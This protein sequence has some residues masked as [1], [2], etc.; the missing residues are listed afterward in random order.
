M[1]RDILLQ[2]LRRN[3]L[4]EVLVLPMAQVI[5]ARRMPTLIPVLA[6]TKGT[7]ESAITPKED[8]V[9][10]ERGTMIAMMVLGVAMRQRSA[11]VE[12]KETGEQKEMKSRTSMTSW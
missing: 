4:E 6:A 1:M 12:A 11:M 3:L 10:V 2:Q 9:V 5:L 7:V 8:K